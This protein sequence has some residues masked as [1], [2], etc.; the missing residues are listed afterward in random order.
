MATTR[1][2][3]AEREESRRYADGMSKYLG[4]IMRQSKLYFFYSSATFT[5]LPYCVRL[6]YYLPYCTPSLRAPPLLPPLL[7]SLA[8]CASLTT[9]L[10]ALPCCVRRPVSIARLCG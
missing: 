1:A 5:F 6:P 7:H 4:C 2:F 10:T 9:S 3:S 8:A